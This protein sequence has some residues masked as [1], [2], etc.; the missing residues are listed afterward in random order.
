MKAI[1]SAAEATALEHFRDP[2]ND[3]D[4]PGDDEDEEDTQEEHGTW[5]V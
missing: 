1:E 5:E 2:E 4:A 3:I